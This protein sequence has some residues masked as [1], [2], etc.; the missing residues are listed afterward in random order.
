[1]DTSSVPGDER[2]L[3]VIGETDDHG[4]ASPLIGQVDMSSVQSPGSVYQ[5]KG[6]PKGG[7]DEQY[8]HADAY[9]FNSCAIDCIATMFKLLKV[10]EKP[11]YKLWKSK[12]NRLFVLLDGRAV[13]ADEPTPRQQTVR[14]IT[15]TL[16]TVTDTYD[17]L[18]SLCYQAEHQHYKLFCAA[19]TPEELFMYDYHEGSNIKRY[20]HGCNIEAAISEEWWTLV[21]LWFCEG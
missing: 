7:F 2:P 5:L 18:G 14:F 16:G 13:E 21:S 19:E 12:L 20:R 15:T 3:S 4:G 10:N 6:L 1:M 11:G 8:P 17:W 9:D